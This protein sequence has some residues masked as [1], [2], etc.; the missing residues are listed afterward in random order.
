MTGNGEELSP[1]Q[2]TAMMALAQ[3]MTHHQAVE[4]AGVSSRQL[5]R[6]KETHS[7]R[8]AVMGARRE[9]YNQSISA[10]VSAM[11]CATA[12]LLEICADTQASDAAR[13]SAA[14]AILEGGLKG[15]GLVDL[16]ER[17]EAL[18]QQYGQAQP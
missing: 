1:K 14:R 2:Q 11:G 15:F 13:V 5:S 18:E 9:I 10:I 8:E 16:S 7:F 12:T 6:W 3:G 17:I 4:V